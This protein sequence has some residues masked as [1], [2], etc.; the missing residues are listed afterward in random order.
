MSA[1]VRLRRVVVRATG[2]HDFDGHYMP[3]QMILHIREDAEVTIQ[4]DGS[5][6]VPAVVLD[7]PDVSIVNVVSARVWTRYTVSEP[8]T[9]EE[10]REI[11]EAARLRR[12]RFNHNA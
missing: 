4:A 5:L 8:H 11:S 3:D 10:F 6:L 1:E 2:E 9:R 12:R 7:D